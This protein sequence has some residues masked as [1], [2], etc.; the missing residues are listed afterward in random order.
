MERLDVERASQLVARALELAP[1]SPD[2]KTLQSTIARIRRDEQERQRAAQ[3]A[4]ERARASLAEG[5][6]ETAIRAASEVLGHYPTHAEA[7][8]L[9]RRALDAIQERREQ[10]ERDRAALEAVEQQKL[11][12]AAGRRSEAIAALEQFAPA[13]AAVSAALADL[14]REHRR[15][16]TAGA[17]RARA[18]RLEQADT[19]R[20]Q[21][22]QQ[23]WV[24]RQLEQARQT[25]EAHQY[26]DA[27]EAL[28]HVERIDPTAP[29]LAALL[30]E[31]RA[32]ESAFRL[33]QQITDEL[34]RIA[35]DL[36]NGRLSDGA[37]GGRVRAHPGAR[38][39]DRASSTR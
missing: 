4:L 27:I 13:H 17:G 3:A 25:M 12:F 23:R 5:H 9:T 38:S 7:H 32:A 2:V 20:R 21:Q 22:A 10:A 29:G 28:E 19:E 34:G 37:G 36:K 26:V 6:L 30:E 39:C 1:A 11:E 33:Q 18:Q 16:R 15:H 35:D 31:A 24:A 8:E 14:R